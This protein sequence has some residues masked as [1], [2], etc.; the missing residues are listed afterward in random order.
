MSERNGRDAV[1]AGWC[2]L[3]PASR[4]WQTGLAVKG[5]GFLVWDEVA[6]EAR[7]RAAELRAVT[8]WRPRRA[9]R[10]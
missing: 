4:A 1:R 3:G 2:G 9:H 10:R 6:S 8:P 5:P 7:K